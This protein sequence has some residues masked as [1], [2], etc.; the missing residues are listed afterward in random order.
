LDK[1][2]G[3]E[4]FDYLYFKGAVAHLLRSDENP[5]QKKAFGPIEIFQ[6]I[7]GLTKIAQND[8]PAFKRGKNCAA[9]LFRKMRRTG[10]LDA[11]YR[12]LDFIHGSWNAGLFRVLYAQLQWRVW[13]GQRLDALA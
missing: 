3:Y 9:A 10:Y 1:S 7:S 6:F 8:F 4:A 12:K 2:V 11:G 5:R 13:E